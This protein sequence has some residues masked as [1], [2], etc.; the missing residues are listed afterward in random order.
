MA[1]RKKL[2][3]CL[4]ELLPLLECL[5]HDLADRFFASSSSRSARWHPACGT[6]IDAGSRA[7]GRWHFSPRS[8]LAFVKKNQTNDAVARVEASFVAHFQCS[9]GVRCQHQQA[10]LRRTV[11]WPAGSS[12]RSVRCSY[13]RETQV[14]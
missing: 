6:F 8:R 13:K 12:L 5:G 2:I 9:A 14:E 4:R 7:L 3:A 10:R 11:V 1:E